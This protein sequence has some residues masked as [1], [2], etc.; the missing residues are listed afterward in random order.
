M[1]DIAF[2][3]RL[4]TTILKPEINLPSSGLTAIFGPSGSG[5]TSLLNALAG[6]V[7]PDHGHIRIDNTVLFD[8]A[9]RVDIAAH[10]RSI[11]Y[12]FQ[13]ARLFPH[14]SVQAN[15]DYGKKRTNQSHP[16]IQSDSLIDLLGIGPLLKRKP[17]TLSGGE[18]QRVAIGRALLAN[19]RVLLLDE[20]MSSLDDARRYE[21]IGYLQKLRA[22]LSVPVML[23]THNRDDVLALA[24]NLV[25]MEQG[26]VTACGSLAAVMPTLKPSRA[27]DD[28]EPAAILTGCIVRH[29]DALQTTIVSFDGGAL[30]LPRIHYP[31]ETHVR[32]RV[33]IRDV[34]IATHPIDN[35]SISNQ[36][37][38]T[39]KN[40]VNNLDGTAT[41]YA[42]VGNT[43]FIARLMAN[44][45][46]RLDLRQGSSVIVLVK[47][48][49]LDA[50][51]V[52]GQR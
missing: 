43:I 2:S 46:S 23:V 45:V 17:A 14:M 22:S 39:I 19:P 20:P 36:L 28:L 52:M 4:G 12:V 18:K 16:I 30:S 3:V 1:I 35:I 32:L 9:A 29:D 33:P 8:S 24:E 11:G 34:M 15:L 25:V 7:R 44:S 21:L 51:N 50:H 41:V 27:A 5:K 38:A 48:V 37:P 31:P 13:D 42:I 6:L 40:I 47:A 26:R 49:T 10:K